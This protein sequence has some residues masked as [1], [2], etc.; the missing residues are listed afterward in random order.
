MAI[1]H[2]VRA[3]LDTLS[4]LGAWQSFYP[5]SSQGAAIALQSD[6][7]T[8]LTAS[9]ARAQTFTPIAAAR[10]DMLQKSGLRVVASMKIDQ[11]REFLLQ[12]QRLTHF[13]RFEQLLITSPAVQGPQ[14]N[15]TLI[16][17][18][19]VVGFAIDDRAL[20][21]GAPTRAEDG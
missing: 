13:V 11:L 12:T 16:L 8:A 15:P 9:Q 5:T 17:T 1:E 14:E 7:E 6:I 19:D 21:T 10:T 18:L 4:S 20:V 3:Q 2:E